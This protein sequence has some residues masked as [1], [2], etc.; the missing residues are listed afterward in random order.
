MR[1]Q[2][3]V[4]VGRGNEDS[5][6]VTF[7]NN[8][9][10]VLI[11]GPCQLENRDHA[12]RLAD[13]IATA[14]RM[15]DV[16][17]VFKSSYDKAN[18]TSGASP[19]GVGIDEGLD[20]L[21]DVRDAIGCPVT[22]DVH[23]E[24]EARVA[25]LVVDMV[26]IPALLSRQTDLLQAAG[27]HARAVNIKKGQF[28]APEDMAHAAAKVVSAGCSNV[29]L[30]ERGTTFGYGRL[31]NDM[32]SLVV[33]PEEAFGLPAVFDATHSVQL[34]SSESGA[35]GGQ[36]EFIAPLARAAIAVGISALF[37]E[38][39]E[40]PDSAPSDGPCMLPLSELPRLLSE[41]VAIDRAVKFYPA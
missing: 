31:V 17:F 25:G 33:M 13:D 21:E 20:I 37:A 6:W 12:L 22:T 41:L 4:P 23:T 18:R 39:H 8:L 29:L 38:V 16:P 1:T 15:H 32:R 24:H 10:F 40:D 3:T 35:S 26:Q 9:P 28:M 30:T 34:P 36:R 19:R 7:G 2:V 14:C 11:A 5:G 27:K